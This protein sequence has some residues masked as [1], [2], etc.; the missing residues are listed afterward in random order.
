LYFGRTRRNSWGGLRTVHGR[1]VGYLSF[2]RAGPQLT[3]GTVLHE[4]AHVVGM[5]TRTTHTHDARFT[6][7]LDSLI[8]RSRLLNTQPG[9]PHRAARVAR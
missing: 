1:R 2:V 9:A 8:A 7:I 3:V 5:W 4:V 6:R